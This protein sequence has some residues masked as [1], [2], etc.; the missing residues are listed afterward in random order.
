VVIKAV[1]KFFASEEVGKRMASGGTAFT[2]FV[3]MFTKTMAN[4]SE[5]QQ[6]RSRR[7]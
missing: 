3:D 1:V 5:Q 4:S 2:A 6:G 7:Q